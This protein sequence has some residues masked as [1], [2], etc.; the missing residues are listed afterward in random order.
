MLR[1]ELL[2]WLL[3]CMGWWS[4]EQ[5]LASCLKWTKGTW[6]VSF[7]C[8]KTHDHGNS[9]KLKY[10][11]GTGLQFQRF[12]PLSSWQKAWWHTG[13]HGAGEGTESSTSRSTGS[14]KR[15][16][17]GLAWAFETSKP[18]PSDTLPPA[19]SCLLMTLHM[20]GHFHLNQHNQC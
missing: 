19:R 10:L 11:I 18:I 6:S 1:G 12:S 13:R 7:C 20:A 5:K 3:T 17:L 4:Q 16:S 9:C 2:A 15:K 8:E 14:R